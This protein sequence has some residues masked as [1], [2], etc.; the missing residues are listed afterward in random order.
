MPRRKE[1]KPYKPQKVNYVNAFKT[2][3]T[4]YKKI[5]FVIADNVGSKQMAKIRIQLRKYKA[6]L[7]MGKNT[8]MKTAIKQLVE[9]NPKFKALPE[10]IK[11]NCGLIFANDNLKEI[12]SLIEA[13]KVQ[14][15]A[16]P[17][18]ITQKTVIIPA[19]NT[20]M[21][22]TK[23]SFFQ[24]LDIPTKITKGTVE[25]VNDYPLLKP[26]DKISASEAQL[27][28]LLKIYPF[29]YG[30]R[31]YKV[32]DEG[33]VYDPEVLEL[34]DDDLL[35][36]F[37]HGVGELAALS[38][39][40]EETNEA[41]VPHSLANAFKDLLAIAVE[42]DY[43]FKQAKDV[44]EFLKDPSKFATAT[45]TVE[46]KDEGKKEEAKKAEVVEEEEKEEEAPMGGGLFE[47]GG[48]D[49]EDEDDD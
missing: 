9:K 25:I 47:E 22:P 2:A 49:D 12:K 10:L 13:D 3:L 19:Q 17:G 33:E 1:N 45:A 23:T 36:S 16:K 30:L 37:Y 24:A 21:E 46:K 5:L 34:T 28:Q 40:I 43:D 35:S 27:L 20:G 44:K 26:G 39:E 7:M 29:E 11:G 41:T 38:L 31:A 32:Y 18:S 4:D 8:L 48:D 14:A 15:P 42:A 6:V